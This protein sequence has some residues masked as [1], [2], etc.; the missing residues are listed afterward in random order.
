MIRGP[1]FAGEGG[2][3]IHEPDNC[4]MNLGGPSEETG[5]KKQAGLHNK[6]GCFEEFVKSL[7][8][9]LIIRKQF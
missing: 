7:F 3:S 2:G 8:K 9:T 6:I 5:R 1:M 4:R